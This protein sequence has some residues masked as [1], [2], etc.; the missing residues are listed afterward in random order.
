MIFIKGAMS[1]E[2]ERHRDWRTGKSLRIDI[3]SIDRHD[4]QQKHKTGIL[5][6]R[7]NPDIE[8]TSNSIA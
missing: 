4:M 8:S 1:V 6:L 2:E 7:L 5:I 3:L